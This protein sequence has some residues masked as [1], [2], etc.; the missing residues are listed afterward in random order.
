MGQR[1]AIILQVR[2]KYTAKYNVNKGTETRV[3]YHQCGI[4]RVLPSQLISILNGTLSVPYY[5]DGVAKQ[6]RPQGCSDI[7]DD[8]NDKERSELDTLTFDTPQKVGEYLNKCD[9]NNGGL[10]VRITI[11]EKCEKES[12]EYAYILG[13]EEGGDYSRFCSGREWMEKT[14]FG[15]IDAGFMTIY[16]NTLQYFG[17]HER[18]KKTSVSETE[19]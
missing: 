14:G 12:I 4:G 5:R 19:D 11:N 8:F 17:A 9:N 18:Y 13:Y 10:F 3:F 7:T 15:S 1:T 6:L 2:N 16:E